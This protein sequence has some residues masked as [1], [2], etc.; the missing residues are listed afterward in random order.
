[1]PIIKFLIGV[2]LLLQNALTLSGSGFSR[3][4]GILLHTTQSGVGIFARKGKKP[5]SPYDFKV[6]FREPGK[7][8]R[9]PTHVHLIIEMYVKNAFNSKLTL[10]L[11][12][13]ILDMFSKIQTIDY[14]PPRLQFFKPEHMNKFT[15]LD[16]V[17][18]FSV[19]FLL[20]VTELIMIQEKTNYPQGSLT[21]KL[22]ADFGIKD[23]FSVIQSAV[24]R[25]R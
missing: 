13:H 3:E 8:E 10:E 18:E 12:R 25:G 9:T 17:G 16:K 4:G 21:Q 7:R 6:S 20:V 14:Y 24:F 1:L 23:R 19:E 11:R 2:I 15:E 22:Y 5:Q